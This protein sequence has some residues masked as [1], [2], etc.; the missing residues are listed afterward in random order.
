[1]T[2]KLNLLLMTTAFVICEFVSTLPPLTP[3]PHPNPSFPMSKI[4]QQ[5]FE[6]HVTCRYIATNGAHLLNGAITSSPNGSAVIAGSI[7][8]NGMYLSAFY[9]HITP[10]AGEPNF[11][12][13]CFTFLA[14][15]T[16]PEPWEVE[17]CQ[18]VLCP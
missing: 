17:G 5:K 16:G 2:V 4:S 10:K 3:T 13:L 14:N 15:Y 8:G 1:M 7:V 6:S 18:V 12:F 11:F 9:A